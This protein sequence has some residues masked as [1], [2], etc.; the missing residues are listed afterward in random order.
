[1]PGP[2]GGSNR[3]RCVPGWAAKSRGGVLRGDPE[4]HGVPGRPDRRV[5][6]VERLAAGDPQLPGHQVDA[7]DLFGDR[8]L[9][10]DAGV[11]LDEGEVARRRRRRGTPPSRR[12][13]SRPQRPGA[14][15]CSAIRSRVS[16]SSRRR[17]L[18]DHLL[19][20]TLQRAVP[21]AER[22]PR[23]PWRV[24]EHLDLDVAYA[25]ADTARRTCRRRRTH[26]R[27]PAAR[28]RASARASAVAVDDPHPLAAAAGAGLEQQRVPV[29][30][31]ERRASLG[32][33][34][35]PVRARHDRDACARPR[36][37]AR[38]AL[39]PI[40]AMRPRIRAH[41]G[42]LRRP[43][44][45]ANSASSDRNPYPGC[46]ES[47]PVASAT[48]TSSVAP[49]VAGGGGRRPDQNR[50]VG[51][52]DVRRAS[53]SAVGVHGHGLDAEVAGRTDRRAR[54]ISPRLATR[55]RRNCRHQLSAPRSAAARAAP[56]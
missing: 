49:Q 11:H 34:E 14:R 46:T 48:C 2:A 13:G 45:R 55:R 31:A 39:S 1:M 22:R 26:R 52:R 3:R 50:A 28:A 37:R 29:L 43:D 53:R 8:V 15:R 56:R 19:M 18:L 40:W 44:R 21:L 27:P 41:P 51:E 4:L 10:L 25:R 7:G 54:A 30:A 23:L 20:A 9:D 16:A 6:P 32:I 12:C 38:A 35:D 36:P 24:A 33:V 42:R 47:Q 5:E 17:R